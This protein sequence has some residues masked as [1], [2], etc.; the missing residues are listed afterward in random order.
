MNT[1]KLNEL[2]AENKSQTKIAAAKPKDSAGNTPT[3]EKPNGRNKQKRKNSSVKTPVEKNDV[4]EAR[5][6]GQGNRGEGVLRVEEFPLFIPGVL[7]DEM[8]RARVTRVNAGHGFARLEEILEPSRERQVPPC[9]YYGRCGGCNMQHQ[10]YSGQLRF[11]TERVRDCFVRIGGFPSPNVLPAMGM[12]VP[13]RYRNK[14]QMPIG[15]QAGELSV[16]FYRGR[17]HEIIDI[18]ECLIQSET[19]DE[20]AEG[21]RSWLKEYHIPVL[22]T[23]EQVPPGVIRH[24]LIREGRYT[25]EYMA[26]LVGSSEDIPHLDKLIERL[27]TTIPD[28]TG[29]VLNINPDVMNR[30]L[31]EKNI[32]LWGNE[33]IIDTIGTVKYRVSPHSFFQVNPDQ[34][35]VM[36]DTVLKLANFK[37]TEHILDLYCGAGSI[38]LYTAEHV[39]HVTGVE[40][41][42]EAIEDANYNKKLNRIENADFILGKSEEVIEELMKEHATPDLVIVDPPRKGCEESLLKAIGES[43]IPKMIYVSCDPATLA[44]DAAIL[45][46]YG[47]EPDIIQPVDNFP[48]THHVEAIILMTRSG[49]GDKK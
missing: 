15:R 34:T 1:N 11:K 31:G 40:I 26:V 45:K 30:I 35:K 2:K 44:R 12:D 14:V 49:S 16:G 7:Q 8:I 19:A 18:N 25:G 9:P 28:L 24:L 27:G 22:E 38:A 37:G 48:Q 47:F 17:S 23:E 32:T 4:I 46:Q 13:W 42:P 39:A 33:S 41:V 3:A 43:S 36:Y 20:I 29:I 5:V 21:I 6:A 10:N